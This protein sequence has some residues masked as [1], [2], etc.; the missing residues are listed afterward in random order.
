MRRRALVVGAASGLATALA[1][2][3]G[4]SQDAMEERPE[5]NRV[6]DAIRSAVGEANTA[7][8]ELQGA[9]EDAESPADVEI[10]ETALQE[11]IDA[12][13]SDLEEARSLD[14]A[15]EYEAELA[16]ASD[17]V[18]VVDGLLTATVE[19]ADV[20]EQLSSL[21]SAI[22]EGEYDRASEDLDA[23][24]PRIQ[25]AQTV[26][27]DAETAVGELDEAVLSDY[28]ARTDELADGLATVV[29]LATAADQLTGGYQLVLDGR[30]HMES[31]RQE[32][33]AGNYGAAESEFENGS[34]EF[35]AATSAFETGQS[36]TERLAG[37]FDTAICRSTNLEEAA[38]H[39]AAAAGEADAGNLLA[40]N[41][42]YQDGDDALDRVSAC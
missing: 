4:P 31:G 37:E 34:G 20:G 7:A 11:R 30:D 17:Y 22:D 38:D 29:E 9:R 26:A 19:F 12:A 2:C 13:R 25:E 40:A 3:M 6:V 24:R 42:E 16:A 32:F 1:G 23:I 10:D 15:G 21:E 8:A 36:E 27:E 39:F 5:E 35:A 33:D 41:D 28:G 18:D 14:A